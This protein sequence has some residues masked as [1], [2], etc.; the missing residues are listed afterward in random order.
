MDSAEEEPS[1]EKASAIKASGS[2]GVASSLE[3]TNNNNIN[4]DMPT[5]KMEKEE[6]GPSN[7]S[8]DP[9]EAEQPLMDRSMDRSSRSSRIGSNNG[10]VKKKDTSETNGTANSNGARRTHTDSDSSVH[11]L[12]RNSSLDLRKMPVNVLLRPEN[13]VLG[14]EELSM[15]EHTDNAYQKSQRDS[16]LLQRTCLNS[17]FTLRSQMML[18]FGLISAGTI[19]L[20]VTVC[21]MVSIISGEVVKNRTRGTFEQVALQ[22]EAKVTRYIAE[23]LTPRLLLDDVVQILYE[24][25]KDRFYGYPQ[26]DDDSKVPYFDTLTQS[27]KYPIKGEPLPMDWNVQGNVNET[28]HMEHLQ[29]RWGLYGAGTVPVSTVNGN[30]FQQGACDPNEQDPTSMN[31]LEGCTDAHNDIA[32]GGVYAPSPTNEQ[33][34]RKASDLAP[35]LKALHEYHQDAKTIG[36][37]FSNSGAGASLSY[38]GIPLDGTTEYESIGCDWLNEPNPMDPSRPILSPEEVDRCSNGGKRVKGAMIPTRE[39]S[40]LDRAWCRDQVIHANHHNVVGGPFLDAWVKGAWFMSVGRAIFDPVTNEFVAC[41][42]LTLD[43][44][45]SLTK[46]VKDSQVTENSRASVVRYQPDG[47]VVMSSAWNMENA[48]STVT[49]DELNV[50]VSREAYNQFFNLVDYNTVW[51][52]SK[53]KDQYDTFEIAG[54]GFRVMAY[55]MP[56]IPDEYDEN[57]EPMFLVL[58]SV[59]ELDLFYYARQVDDKVD[60]RVR[61]LS[62]LSVSVGFAG[63]VAVFLVLV[64]VS[65][66]I[67]RPLRIMNETA[68]T[69]IDNFG[70]ETQKIEVEDTTKA[71]KDGR[72]KTELSEIVKEFQR[73]VRKFSGGAMARSAKFDISEV[74]NHFQMMEDFEELYKSRAQPSF[75]YN[76]E[77]PKASSFVD[78]IFSRQHFGSNILSGSSSLSKSLSG[79]T[80]LLSANRDTTYASPLFRWIVALIVFPLLLSTIAISAVVIANVATELPDM[81]NDAERGLVLLQ[82]RGLEAFVDLR[83]GFVSK[84][85]EQSIRDLHLLTRYTSWL[86][87]GAL[88]ATTFQ[89]VFSG[90]DYCKAYAD[91]LQDCPWVQENYV[92]DCEWNDQGEC[93]DYSEKGIDSRYLQHPYFVASSLDTDINGNIGNTSFPAVASSANTT[94]YFRDQNNIVGV[95]EGRKNETRE[96]V[97]GYETM[98]RRL[99]SVAGSPILEPLYNYRI[100]KQRLSGVF[101]M[102]EQDGMSLA[103]RGCS[104]TIHAHHPHWTSTKANGAAE[105]RPELC[106]LGELHRLL[107]N[108]KALPFP[109]SLTFATGKH[110][111]DPRC[112]GWYDSGRKLFLSNESELYVTPP[113]TFANEVE[114]GQS[115]TAPLYDPK[116][117]A[118]LGQLL[119]DFSSTRIFDSLDDSKTPLAKGGHHLLITLEPDIYG[120]DTVIG[121][122]LSLREPALPLEDVVPAVSETCDGSVCGFAAVAANMRAGKAGNGTFVWDPENGTPTTYHVAYR[123]V[124]IRRLTQVDSSDFSRGVLA[125]NYGIYS[126][127]LAEPE[128]SM[129]DSFEQAE[130]DIQ[131]VI[132]IGLAVLCILIVVAACLVVWLSHRITISMTEPMYYLL[133]LMRHINR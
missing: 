94:A 117:K 47:L 21:L 129:L 87:F 112:R 55:P 46:I 2:T 19:L 121:P 83:S 69:I 43:V 5:K 74:D 22:L 15:E 66:Y 108:L 35:V 86:L 106:P 95:P 128:A 102:F 126:I 110:G 73:M 131:S 100:E 123:N 89:K 48:T 67:T 50:G 34:Y 12:R 132:H 40:N 45:T 64:A 18:S 7:N 114:I 113:Y 13:Q 30:Y 99:R 101:I 24:A 96:F 53:I 52:S 38:P 36:I 109:N 105:L 103:S 27:N 10:N 37:F 1:A 28:N 91:N 72:I 133:E 119:V 116:T 33:V 125:D 78:S 97:Q 25:T 71:V 8:V 76:A 51:N 118:H 9:V 41:T 60:D 70:D 31:Y 20:V 85:S 32:T 111:Y 88:E 79:E 3:S 81:I 16:S 49:I 93:T 39:Y 122:G 56:P 120:A 23:D 127:A 75:Q 82:V 98:Y 84:A 62:I 54:G 104:N 124:T 63:L 90:A 57:Y 42:L 61:N 68:I 65:H 58:F 92:C 6:P 130:D 107:W 14:S 80:K 115:C 77:S 4:S 26:N 29:G 17:K 11:Q 59:S 44:Q